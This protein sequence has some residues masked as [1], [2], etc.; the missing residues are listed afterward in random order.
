MKKNEVFLD[1][2]S[3]LLEG[4][5]TVVRLEPLDLKP[6]V[7]FCQ[8]FQLDFDDGYQYEVAEKY[9]LTIVSFDKG[10]ER[11]TR[12]RRTPGE[13]IVKIE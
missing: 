1:F 6:V 5:T 4:Q 10:F 3:D 9:D 12:G 2:L 13:V 8:Q 7:A 11:T